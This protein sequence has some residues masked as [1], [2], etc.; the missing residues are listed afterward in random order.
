M[1]PS[2]FL[3][4]LFIPHQANN[5]RARILHP[6]SILAVTTAFLV[7]QA[8]IL[9][10]PRFLPVALGYTSNI[11]PEEIVELT[12]KKRE[13]N[14]ASKLEL[15][16]S[17]TKAALAK[18]ADMFA[19]DYW[20]H[21][22]PD[23]SPPWHFFTEAEYQYRYAGENL[24][25]DFTEPEDVVAAWMS[26]AS[27]RENMLSGRYQDVGVAVVEGELKGVRTTLVVQLF[28][29]KLGATGVSQQLPQKSES[30]V[31]GAES[32]VGQKLVKLSPFSATKKIAL[33]LVSVFVIV[34][35]VDMLVL[36]K[37]ASRR[38]SRGF[39]HFGFFAMVLAVLLLSKSGWIV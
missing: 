33:F 37:A 20:A 14:G 17:L 27:H 19:R 7:M 2:A 25:R 24:A 13:E 26:S 1:S 6:I 3:L 8:L 34:A 9:F 4:G 16:T 11:P 15:D 29:T 28:G 30:F 22:G 21:N 5:H 12:N 36:E 18:A 39:A 32:N 23:G 31:A 10:A 38:A 35:A